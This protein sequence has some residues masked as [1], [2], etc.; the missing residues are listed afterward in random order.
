MEIQ[1]GDAGGQIDRL[2]DEYRAR[3]LWFLRDNYYPTT[4]SERLRVLGYIEQ[5]GDRDAFR[6]A[7][8]LKNWLLHPSNEKSANASL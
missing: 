3:G 8:E 4:T 1:D 6:R 7:R 5:H 2:T